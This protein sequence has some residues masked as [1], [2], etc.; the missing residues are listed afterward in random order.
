MLLGLLKWWSYW[1]DSKP[2]SFNQCSSSQGNATYTQCLQMAPNNGS[3]RGDEWLSLAKLSHFEEDRTLQYF[4]ILNPL[5][6]AFWWYMIK[7][8]STPFFGLFGNILI[9]FFWPSLTPTSQNI[10]SLQRCAT[11]VHNYRE[12]S[13]F[14][15]HKTCSES[16]SKSQIC[17]KMSRNH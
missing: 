2:G 17:Q 9:H 8:Y 7:K 1:I 14:T 3:Y 10:F 11:M 16:N 4:K 12:N 13:P 6:H 5:L 15:Y